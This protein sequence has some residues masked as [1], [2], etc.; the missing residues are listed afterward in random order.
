MLQESDQQRAC[1][2]IRGEVLCPRWVAYE[3]DS[4]LHREVKGGV[5]RFPKKKVYYKTKIIP[6]GAW[7]STSTASITRP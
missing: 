6:D 7:Y 3:E 2:K 1:T 5:M 4:D